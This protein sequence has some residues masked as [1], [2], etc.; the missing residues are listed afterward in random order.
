[1]P[2]AHNADGLFRRYPGKFGGRY[3]AIAN[4]TALSTQDREDGMAVIVGVVPASCQLWIFVAGSDETPGATVEDPDDAAGDGQ[5]I[6]VG[7]VADDSTILALLASTSNGE[8]AALVGLEDAGAFTAATNLEAAVAEIYQHL[9]TAN[10]HVS[11]PLRSAR[12]VSSGGDV[13][14]I[15]ANGGVLASDTTPILRADANESEEVA[16]VADDVDIVSWQV[17]LPK[18][19]DGTAPATVDVYVA[20]GTTDAASFALLTSWDAATQVT[21]AFDDAASKSATFHV[22][23]ATIAAAD[24]P[25]APTTVTLQLV[26]PAHTTN[27]ILLKAV[28]MNYKRKLLTA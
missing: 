25:D 18:D 3:A 1:M 24:I 22:V 23:T 17:D 15:A 26:P 6:Q 28:R 19:F 27:A 11:F 5:W 12:E 4:V 13:D 20:S 2:G 7:V 21:D 10:A 14:D 8:G 9:K 16:W